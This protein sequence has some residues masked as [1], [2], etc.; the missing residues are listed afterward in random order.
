MQTSSCSGT[1]YTQEDDEE[2]EEEEEEEKKKTSKIIQSKI[3]QGGEKEV[4][5]SLLVEFPF[6]ILCPVFSSPL[7]KQ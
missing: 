7:V 5:S 1:I 2:E 3:I 4:P 6:L